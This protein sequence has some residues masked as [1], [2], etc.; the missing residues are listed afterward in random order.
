MWKWIVTCLSP[1]CLV[2]VTQ[3]TQAPIAT[4]PMQGKQLELS[5][6][7]FEA[8]GLSLDT[9]DTIRGPTSVLIR[10]VHS[11]FF[12]IEIERPSQSD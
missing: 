2:R 8:Y 10:A 6:R 1:E 11:L 3:I 9:I 5:G 4:K 7:G 12:F